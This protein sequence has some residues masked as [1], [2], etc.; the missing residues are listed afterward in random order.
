L[1]SSDAACGQ[2]QLVQLLHDKR[3]ICIHEQQLTQETI[4]EKGAKQ[5]ANRVLLTRQSARGNRPPHSPFFVFSR[6]TLQCHQV[7]T[8]DKQSDIGLWFT[9]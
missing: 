4:D 9:G 3:Y 6:S 7:V 8:A 1:T 2:L 5:T